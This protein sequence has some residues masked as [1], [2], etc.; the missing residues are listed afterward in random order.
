ME[1]FEHLQSLFCLTFSPVGKMAVVH[2]L[3]R[4]DHISTLLKYFKEKVVEK[5]T[6]VKKSPGKSF[7]ADLI[8][9]TVKYSDHVPF[10]QKYARELL[11]IISKDTSQE[12]NE[13]VSWLKPV[14]NPAV[15][16]YEDISG[17]VEIIKK[18]IENA[19]AL[20]GEMITAVKVLKYLGVPQREKEL[21]TSA[22]DSFEYVELKYK[23]VII[24]LFSLEGITHLSAV[25]QKLCEHYEQPTLHS[26]RL[27]GRQGLALTAFLRPAMQLIRK[28]LSQ[29]IK[30]RNT[31]F[32]DLTTIPILLQTYSLMQA[33]P[34]TAHAHLNAQ[35]V[36]LMI[37][38]L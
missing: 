11:D 34:V 8:I 7:L 12:L 30:C 24:Q 17:L 33:I 31:E 26:A 1:V 2:V 9:M 19:T 3:S 25:I 10:L 14:E 21:S 15:F 38:S 4:G 5:D 27:V 13:L 28:V 6:K 20:P 22:P 35:K 36:V 37:L 18:N 23:C 32:K 29:V 16:A